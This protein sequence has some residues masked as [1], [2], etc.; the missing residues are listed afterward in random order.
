[1]LA[2]IRKLL[3]LLKSEEKH[4]KYVKTLK[5]YENLLKERIDEFNQYQAHKRDEKKTE[6]GE[7]E[8]NYK[9][10]TYP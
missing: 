5:E 6:G 1:M 10:M 8:I 3:G 9:D 2:H 4:K 7:V